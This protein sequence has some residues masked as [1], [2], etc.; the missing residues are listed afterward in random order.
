MLL[1][2]SNT[3]LLD[4]PTNHLDLDSKDVLLEAL[5]DYG[6]TLIFVSHDRYFVEKLANRV[7]E[8]GGGEA[9][10]YPGRYDEFLWS[11]GQRKG[12]APANQPSPPRPGKPGVEAIAAVAPGAAATAA[13]AKSDG[14]GEP[15]SAE[16]EARRRQALS[17]ARRRERHQKALRTRVTELEETIA[18]REAEI[19]ALE[20]QM[21]SDGFYDNREAVQPVV[22]RH[23][24]LMWEVGDLMHKWEELQHSLERAEQDLQS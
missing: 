19:K 14:R 8:V 13:T 17:E 3:L 4:E 2:P 11:K 20:A 9:H 22:D 5:E 18:A 6:G 15:S 1:R 12:P 7:V 16:R 24:A 10:S 23:Q 21:A